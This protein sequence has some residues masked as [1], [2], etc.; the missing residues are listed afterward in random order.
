[1]GIFNHL[2]CVDINRGVRNFQDTPGAVLLDVRVPHLYARRHI[3]AAGTSP[4]SSWTRWRTWSRT[5]T[6]PLRLRPRGGDQRQGR[7][8]AEGHGVHPGPQHRGHEALLRQPGVPGAGGGHR[9]GGPVR[10]GAAPRRR[11]ASGRR[12][13]PSIGRLNPAT[14]GRGPAPVGTDPTGS[15]GYYPP[16]GAAPGGMPAGGLHFSC[17][18]WRKEHQRGEVLPLDSPLWSGISFGV[19]LFFVSWPAA[20]YPTLASARPPAGRAGGGVS[21]KRD[22]GSCPVTSSGF[23]LGGSCHRR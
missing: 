5:T 19:S 12:T 14:L 20:L 6:S 18:K 8:P 1:M 22:M 10:G 17:E 2:F 23:P 21:Y 16:R 11:P 15:R 13:V 3:P 9:L 4:S 7:R